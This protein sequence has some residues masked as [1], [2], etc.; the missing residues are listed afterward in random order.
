MSIQ[1]VNTSIINITTPRDFGDMR[2]EHH[3]LLRSAAVAEIPFTAILELTGKNSIQFINGLITN[4]VKT[5][6]TGDGTLAAFLN[7]QGKI[8]SLCRFYQVGEKLL[9]EFNG[10]NRETIF[11]N[12]S[13]FV[14]AGEFFVKDVSD[15]KNVLTVQGPNAS[16]VLSKLTNQTI[17][18]EPEYRNFSATINGEEIL[19]ASHFRGSTIGFDLFVPGNSKAEIRQALIEAGAVAA[20]SEALEIFR[21]EAGIPR[22][23]VDFSDAN[24]L[25]ETGLDKSVSY[26]K[27]CYLGQEVIARIHW[28]GQPK[29][30]LRGLLIEAENAPEK[31]VELWSEDGKKIGEITSSVKSLALD[32]FIAL[33]YVHRYYL[34]VGTKLILKSGDAEIGS[35][36]VAETPFKA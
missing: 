11:K 8:I 27:G 29:Q 36:T 32:R 33:G 9:I 28:R 13:R 22:D 31:G 10:A 2:A 4:D 16:E 7:V 30:Q 24:I 19:I 6:Q 34:T 5:L 25:L 15:E 35:A 18:A 21:L 23:G 20:G 1:A 12:L 26:T 14:P 17:E 3:A